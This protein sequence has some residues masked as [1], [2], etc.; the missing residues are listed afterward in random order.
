MDNYVN[1]VAHV[2]PPVPH[3]ENPYALIYVPKAMVGASNLLFGA[4]YAASEV[5]SIDVT[6]FY[7]ILA[8]SAFHLRGTQIKSGGSFD[9]MARGFRAKSFASLQKAL[10]EPLEVDQDKALLHPSLPSSSHCEAIISAMLTMIT[11]DVMEGSMSEYWIHLD[12]VDRLARQLRNEA[13]GSPNIDR[14]ITISSFLSTLADTTSLELPSTPWTE[15]YPDRQSHLQDYPTSSASYRLEIAYGITPTLADIMKRIVRLSQN[16]SYHVSRS[17]V[18][19][20]TLISACASLL[21]GLSHWSIDSEPLV[22]LFSTADTGPRP[23]ADADFTLQLAKN[24]ILAFAHALRVYYHTRIQ[25]CTPSEMS[26]FV[27]RVASHL[28]AIE[29]SKAQAGYDFDIAATITWPGF[30]ASCEAARG[31]PRDIWYRWWAGMLKYRIGNM[32]QLWEIVQEA[33]ALRDDEGVTE[34]PAWM[35]VLR[36]SGKRILAI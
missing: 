24:H 7:A 27:E 20:P 36:R 23:S 18:L 5:P 10:Q 35:P 19:P 3:P 1:L 33:W 26:Q 17:A 13:Q 9:L 6:I 30:I 29:E 32:V 12:G 22:Q 25:P 2:L 21:D 34:V 11:M 8:T 14:L 4:N 16:I 31:H 15:E 28:M